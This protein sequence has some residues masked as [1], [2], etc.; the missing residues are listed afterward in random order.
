MNC[1]KVQRYL[2]GYC[3]GELPSGQMERI[4]DHLDSCPECAKEATEIERINLLL[5][6]DVETLIPSAD[7]NEKLLAK[8]RTFPSEAEATNKMSWWQKL[9]HEVFPSVKLRWAMV[10]AASVMVVAFAVVLTRK[11]PNV[12]PKFLPE[13]GAGMESRA[14]ATSKDMMDSSYQNLMRR[15]ART[16]QIRGGKTFVIDNFSFSTSRLEDGG[17]RPE[18]LYKRFVLDKK[19]PVNW[20]REG[21]SRYVLPV[22]S[23]QTVSQKKDY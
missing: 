2:F 15:L 7:F 1:R 8:I 9:L 16:S 13:G 23:T 5:K 11:S 6:D 19:T 18:G 21:G 17:I 10:G 12:A 22:V 4:K 14:S 3:K 20:Q